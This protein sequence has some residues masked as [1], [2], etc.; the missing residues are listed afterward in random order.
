M[1]VVLLLILALQ[2]YY[3]YYYMHID[4]G[5]QRRLFF[6]ALAHT[7]Y[8]YKKRKRIYKCKIVAHSARGPKEMGAVPGGAPKTFC[9]P[10]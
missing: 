4:F 5:S 2:Y 3:Y 10:V 8:I 7:K 9:E 1:G 6:V